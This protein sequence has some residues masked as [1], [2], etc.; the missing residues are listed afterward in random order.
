MKYTIFSSTYG[1]R[2]P[3]LYLDVSSGGDLDTFGIS[4]S[5]SGHRFKSSPS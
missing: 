3:A 1:K 5:I 2:L 4:S